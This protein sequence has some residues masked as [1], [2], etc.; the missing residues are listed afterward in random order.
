LTTS[1]KLDWLEAQTDFVLAKTGEK[2]KPLVA[3]L[4]SQQ[5]GDEIHLD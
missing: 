4:I 5:M 3:R 1:F 2:L